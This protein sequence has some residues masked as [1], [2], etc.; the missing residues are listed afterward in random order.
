MDFYSCKGFQDVTATGLKL[1]TKSEIQLSTMLIKIYCEFNPFNE[2]INFD[3]SQIHSSASFLPC[4]PLTHL[5]ETC[6]NLQEISGRI[7][8]RSENFQ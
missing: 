4:H 8:Y 1:L 6:L 3:K 7:I 2:R 5:S